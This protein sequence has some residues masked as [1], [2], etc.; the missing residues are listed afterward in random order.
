MER[1][2]NEAFLQN[3]IILKGGLTMKGE[4]IETNDYGTFIRH[5][6]LSTE[7]KSNIRFWDSVDAAVEGLIVDMCAS[8]NI[9][10]ID[11][12]DID[13]VKEVVEVLTKG[14]EKIEYTKIL[15]GDKTC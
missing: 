14:I 6:E 7:K 11:W 9:Q 5:E 4:A 3:V 1:L 13:F 2:L 15:K 10:I 12:E 8:A